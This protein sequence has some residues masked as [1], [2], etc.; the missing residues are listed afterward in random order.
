VSSLPARPFKI[1]SIDGGGIR[2][3]CPAALLA[4]L[5]EHLGVQIGDYFDLMAGTSTGGILVLGLAAGLPARELR[6]FYEQDGPVVFPPCRSRWQAAWGAARRYLRTRH[7]AAPLEA[8]L[9][10]ALGDRTMGQLKR[11]VVIPTFDAGAGEI[12]LIKTP[13]HLRLIRDSNRTLVEVGLATSAAPTYLPGHTSSRGERLLDGGLWA[14]N[15]IAVAVVEAVGYLR[16]P[17]E[18]VRVLSLGTTRAPYDYPMGAMRAGILGFAGGRAREAVFAAQM[19]GAHAMAKVLLGTD[20][21]ILRLDPSVRDG[22]FEMDRPEGIPELIALGEREAM[23]N[24]ES[25]RRDFLDSTAAYQ[26]M[27]LM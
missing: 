13:H 15:P 5:E 4:W 7:T 18:S 11:R 12:R 2:G 23:H 22:R 6:R 1:L 21:R 3:A 9:R 19:T 25:I 24:C 27:S 10:R 17:P 20:A 8:A 14:N 26:G 16:I